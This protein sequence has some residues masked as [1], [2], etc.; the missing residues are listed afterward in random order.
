VPG[1]P[2]LDYPILSASAPSRFSCEGRRAGKYS[3]V[4][5]GT[6]SRNEIFFGGLNILITTFF[7]CEDCFQSLS[8]AFHYP[9][10]LL[11]FICFFEITY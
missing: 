5:K 6:V 8:K 10:K 9:I 7:E 11:T 3:K 2:G 4:I 1:E